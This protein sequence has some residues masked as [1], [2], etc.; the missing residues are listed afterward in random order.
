LTITVFDEQWNPMAERITYVNNND[1]L[2]QPEMNVQHWGLNK[3]ARNEIQLLVPDSLPANFSV[4]VT[5]AGIDADSSDN[6]V[7]HLM[8]MGDIK[9][10]VYNPA[11]YFSNVN[12]TTVQ[13][14]DLVMLT[15]GWRRFKWNNVVKGLLPKI[16]FPRDT[17]YLSLSG[18]VYGVLPAQLKE[19]PDIIMIINQ[20]NTKGKILATPIEA[21]G[22]FNEPSLVLFDTAHIYYRLSKGLEG[23]SASFLESRLPS[24]RF[25][26][27]AGNRFFNPGDTTGNARHFQLS[28]ESIQLLKLYEGKVLENVIVKAKTRSPMEIMDEKYAS[29]LFA[30]GDAYQ[31]DLLTDPFASTSMNIFTYLQGKV[32]GLQVN[33][34]VNPPTMTWRG[35]S[36]QVFVNEVATDNGMVATMTPRDVAYIKVFRPPFFGGVGGGA[37]GGIAI[38]TRK[39]GDEKAEPGKGLNNTVVTGYTELKQFYSPNYSTFTQANEKKDLRTTLY[40]NPQVIIPPGKNQ[41]VLTFYNNDVSKAFRVIIEGMSSDGRLAHIEQI[42][43]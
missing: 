1:Y 7:S 5:D 20:K 11:S 10:N 31:F 3:R 37:G 4:S 38:Y 32:A 24:L 36:P 35:G 2:F 23:A 40:W 13:Y 29:G 18:R 21:D 41:A 8:L 33:T 27:A 22:T 28:D 9:G 16:I 30:G 17:S 6:I 26:P 15:N 34:N 43:E 19:H 14:L 39:G 42:M 12:D 25:N